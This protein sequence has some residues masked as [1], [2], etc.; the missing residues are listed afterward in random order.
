MKYLKKK[1]IEKVVSIP[2]HKT[3]I[4]IRDKYLLMLA[5]LEKKL[6]SN[7]ITS[8]KAYQELSSL[9]RNFIYE[10]TNIK[11]QNYTLKEIGTLNMPILYELV[12]EYYDPEFAKISKGNITS[13]INKAKVVIEKWN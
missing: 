2:N 10:S 11:V 12:A 1:E 5:E 9:I 3:L 8:R 7:S 6:N 13:S 4:N